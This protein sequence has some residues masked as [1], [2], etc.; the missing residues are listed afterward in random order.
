MIRHC[1]HLMYTAFHKCMSVSMLSLPAAGTHA[2][3]TTES[4]P[5]LASGLQ[6]L[7]TKGLVG[8][9][10]GLTLTGAGAEFDGVSREVTINDAAPNLRHHL[11]KR[12]TQDDIS[13]RTKAAIV[14]RG[15]YLP[16]GVTDPNEKALFLKCT[17]G[18][19]LT[20]VCLGSVAWRAVCQ[21]P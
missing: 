21:N 8:P 6:D 1:V 4:A 9:G 13:K 17:P 7:V 11:T 15:R 16:A 20:E 10:Q 5:S 14:V 19:S 18:L 3:H 12:S 2:E